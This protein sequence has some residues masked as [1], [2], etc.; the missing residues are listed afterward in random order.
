MEKSAFKAFP[1]FDMASVEVVRGP[2]GTLFGR[3]TTAGIVHIKSKRPTEGNRRLRKT[4][5]W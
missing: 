4:V 1:I 5:W 2:Q 3:N